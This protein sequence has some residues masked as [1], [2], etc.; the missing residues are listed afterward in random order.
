MTCQVNEQ[1][2]QIVKQDRRFARLKEQ[3]TEQR[4]AARSA[5][6]V[7]VAT[8]LR[9]LEMQMA[10]LQRDRDELVRANRETVY[11]INA[12]ARAHG[13]S[14][15]RRRQAAAGRARCEPARSHVHDSGTAFALV[16][17]IG[18]SF[19]HRSHTRLGPLAPAEVSGIPM[20][21]RLVLLL[22]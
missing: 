22:S 20:T 5:G 14:P 11:R 12:V 8:A 17:S 15:G 21:T 18:K 7:N 13:R 19:T 4:R 16:Q 6:S 3:I 10:D 2:Q 1:T 9:N